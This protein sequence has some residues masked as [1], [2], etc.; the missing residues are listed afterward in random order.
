MTEF[1]DGLIELLR[2]LF[3]RGAIFRPRSDLGSLDVGIDWKLNTDPER[4]NKRSKLIT[5]RLPQ[6]FVDD[7]HDGAPSTRSAM[8][9]RLVRFVADKLRGFNPDHSA[10]VHVPP[11]RELWLLT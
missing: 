8:S 6:E 3:P 5:L 11:P 4:P 10:S 2:P 7:Y 9:A 1:S